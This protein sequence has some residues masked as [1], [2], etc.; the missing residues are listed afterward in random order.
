[1]FAAGSRTSA[2]QV[3]RILFLSIFQLV[4][5]LCVPLWNSGARPLSGGQS[6][7]ADIGCRPLGVPRDYLP[8]LA[9]LEALSGLIFAWA[10]TCLVMWVARLQGPTFHFIA[11]S[12]QDLQ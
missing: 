1:M 10:A 8:R 3:A 4:E 7:G 6:K 12:G 9:R 2:P 5:R 11:G